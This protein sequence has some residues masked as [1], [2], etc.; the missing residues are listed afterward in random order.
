GVTAKQPGTATF[1]DNDEILQ[2]SP[3]GMS[4]VK[5]TT[6]G[7]SAE[8]VHM[9]GG[10]IN[11]VSKSGTN[12][13]HGSLGAQYIWKSLG[14]RAYLDQSQYNNVPWPYAW[15]NGSFNEIGRD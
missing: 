9:A 1:G 2:M 13:P 5:V 6:N 3:E 7:F 14:Q 4:E 12:Q 8:Y 15:F 11:I 10:G